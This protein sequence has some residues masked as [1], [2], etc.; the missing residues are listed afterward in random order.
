MI[1]ENGLVSSD[2]YFVSFTVVG[3]LGHGISNQDHLYTMLP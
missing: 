2:V 3:L 1:S